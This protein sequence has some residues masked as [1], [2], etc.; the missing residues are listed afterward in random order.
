MGFGPPVV[1]VILRRLRKNLE[2]QNGYAF[3]DKPNAG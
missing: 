1:R 3:E 2:E